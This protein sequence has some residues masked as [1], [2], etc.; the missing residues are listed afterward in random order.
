MPKSAGV[1]SRG[2]AAL[3]HS[4]V[5]PNRCSRWL[6]DVEQSAWPPQSLSVPL[7]TVSMCDS[8]LQDDGPKLGIFGQDGGP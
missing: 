2:A 8:T 1:T 5:Y 3:Y 4:A 6:E 7:G